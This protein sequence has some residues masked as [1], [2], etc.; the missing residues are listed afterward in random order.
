MLVDYMKS[1]NTL[2]DIEIKK[3]NKLFIDRKEKKSNNVINNK[4]INNI[5]MKKVSTYDNAK[6]RLYK[7][8]LESYRSYM[9]HKN[10][11]ILLNDIT[12]NYIVL[13]KNKTE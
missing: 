7:Y 12:F 5:I 11:E 13:P 3:I 8:M 4:L 2:S 10:P 6:D 9:I 1:I